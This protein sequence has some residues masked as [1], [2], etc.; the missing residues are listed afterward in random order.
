MA[1]KPDEE[2]IQNTHNLPRFFLTQRQIAWVSLVFALAWGVFGY[3]RMPQRKDPDIP[4]RLALTAVVW[5]GVPAEQVEQ[6]VTKRLERQIS[7]N[8]RVEEIRSTTKKGV[9]VI[10]F[11]LVDAKGYDIRKE[12]DDIKLRLDQITDLPPG[13]GPIQFVKDFGDTAA[14]MLT[15]ASPPVD[16]AEVTERARAVTQAIQNVRQNA[17]GTRVSVV[18]GYPASLDAVDANRRIEMVRVEMEAAGALRDVRPINGPSFGGFDAATT[19]SDEQVLAAMRAAAE[20]RLLTDEIHPDTWR[21]AVI[22]NVNTVRDRL[23]AVATDKYTYSD[24]DD[25]T[26][27]VEKS[28]KTLSIV[29]KV[30]RTGA[31]EERIYL[32]YSQERLAE[33]GLSPTAIQQALQA[34]NVTAA[35]PTASAGGRNISIAPTGEFQN[36][37]ELNQVL[38]PTG[39]NGSIYL[40]DLVT[41]RRG[42]ESPPDFLNRFTHRDDKGQW[43]TNRAITLSVQ[44]RSGQQIAAFG[45]QVDENL[46]QVRKLLPGDLTFARTSDQPRQVTED[47]GLFMRSLLEAIG[48]VVLVS[49]IGFWSW[50]TAVLMACA[51]PVT[52]ALTFGMMYVLDIDLQQVSIA[53]LII[54]L[55][56]LVD[57]PVVSGDAIE[58]ELGAG[59]PRDVA[60][61]LGP[62]KLFVAMLFATITNIAAYLPF[63]SL[64]GDTGRFLYTLP[65]VITV[66]LLASL[67]VAMTFVPLIASFLLKGKHDPPIEERRTKG[68]G[69]QYYRVGSWAI[70]HR[71][72]VLLASLLIL[73]GG[74]FIMTRLKPQFFP[75][76]LQ[77]LSYADV[78]MPE[79][80]TLEST[81]EAALAAE[82]VIRDVSEKY[83]QE[84]REDGKPKP[85]LR[86]MTTF[87]GGGGPRFWLSASPE[88]PKL[89][90]AQ[91]VVETY[92][93][94]DTHELVLLWQEA[95]SQRVPGARVDMRELET[96][97][98]IGTPVQVRLSGDD[99]G[100]LWEQA[101][102]L[103][104]IFRA[105]PKSARVYDDWGTNTIEADVRVDPDRANIAGVTNADVSGSLAAAYYGQPIASLQTGDKQIPILLRMRMEE[106][107]QLG[108][109]KNLYVFSQNTP[110]R[111][112]LAQVAQVQYSSQPATIQ[113]YNQ[114]RTITVQ[115]FVEPGALA[116]EVL[117][118]AMPQIEELQ[119]TLPPGMRL[120]I[121]GEYEEQ[122]KGFLDLTIVLIISIVMIYLA[123]TAQFR[124]AI[125]PFIVFAAIPYGMVGA[126]I[127]L[128][129]MG[130]PFGFMAFLGLVSLVGVIVSH[131]IVLFDFI[132]ERRE[133][134]EPLEMALLDAGILRLRPVV[135]TVA[136][137]VTALIPLAHN[138]GPLWEPLCFAQ[139]GGLTMATFVTLLLVPVLYATLVKDTRLVKWEQGDEH[140]PKQPEPTAPPTDQLVE[141]RS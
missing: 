66:S 12:L 30:E 75:I 93:K 134:G 110:A 117:T 88:P 101:E 96:G 42:Y 11:E 47:V 139:I 59:K 8:T 17:Q 103:K 21:P 116:S 44:M 122:N 112:P 70:E 85:M 104:A 72:K 63:L 57:V 33:Y 71:K 128:W 120:Q 108:N 98:P 28:L 41:I 84:H 125:K 39:R 121:A 127:A 1:H 107:A 97:A 40:R 80:A 9:S 69:A 119:R 23:A 73:V 135:I 52:L 14:L 81:S 13:A 126:L 25:F 90:Y 133:M 137:T 50:R 31:L 78:W 22:R 3:F 99:T 123:L 53:T 76:D 95:L 43:S 89:N 111:V 37:E 140:A 92:D 55:G 114:Y 7:Q 45:Q 34:R 106:R 51:I 58:R 61:W 60:A 36:A 87:V 67:L 91:I 29:S 82:Q 20:R 102:R 130:I 65:V 94:H 15:V 132:E 62:T 18:V 105:I 68:F 141:V 32:E 109:L 83:S 115:S 131:I 64:P 49:L 79:D 54:A 27:Q 48:L 136:A 129:V 74:G 4:L 2:R 100:Q 5:P 46:A 19:L 16:A 38:L 56:L 35:G 113:R 118:A 86:H 24:L 26:D 10:I 6:L 138:G 77:Y 124:H